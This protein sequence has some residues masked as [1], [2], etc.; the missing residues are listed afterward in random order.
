[1]KKSLLLVCLL[2][3][4]AQATRYANNLSLLQ[5][6]EVCVG[7]PMFYMDGRY[8]SNPTLSAEVQ[9]ILMGEA[10]RLQINIA[11]TPE[12]DC[13]GF[14]Y[15]TVNVQKTIRG[16]IYVAHLDLVLQQA[17][18]NDLTSAYMKTTSSS[19]KAMYANLWNVEQM[20]IYE[21]ESM[22]RPLTIADSLNLFSLFAEDWKAV[23]AF[24]DHD[25]L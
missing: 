13:V 15:L 24:S 25:P 22:L 23:H 7:L 14:V 21:Q 1:M 10:T 3:G 18:L 17:Q 9:R 8:T 11:A 20:G 2:V 16:F 19:G 6:S 4:A 12:E 5:P